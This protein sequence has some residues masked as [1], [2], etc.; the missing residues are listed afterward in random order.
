MKYWLYFLLDGDFSSCHRYG[1]PR[2]NKAGSDEGAIEGVER[3]S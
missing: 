1:N 3:Q 2:T